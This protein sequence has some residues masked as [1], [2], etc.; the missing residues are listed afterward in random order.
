MRQRGCGR[1]LILFL[2]AT[3][4]AVLSSESAHAQGGYPNKPVRII[5][6]YA[7]GAA[8]TWSPA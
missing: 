2:A 5:V 7:A 8:P 3:A 1:A 6:G 4:A